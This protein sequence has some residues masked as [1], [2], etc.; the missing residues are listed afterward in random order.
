[1]REGVR[2]LM[3]MKPC[4]AVIGL[5]PDADHSLEVCDAN[6]VA[7]SVEHLSFWGSGAWM[8]EGT[9]LGQAVNQLVPEATSD[10]ILLWGNPSGLLVVDWAVMTADLF[11]G[12]RSSAGGN[13]SAGW[14]FLHR[15]AFE[16]VNGC[17]PLLRSPSLL[18]TD[19]LG[20]LEAQ[21]MRLIPPLHC[22]RSLHC[23]DQRNA[24]KGMSQLA[25]MTWQQAVDLARCVADL[26]ADA[27]LLVSHP[28]GPAQTAALPSSLQRKWLRIWRLTFWSALLLLPERIMKTCP[29][30]WFPA[31]HQDM[32]KPQPWQRFY[33]RWLRLVVSQL[34]R[35][36][37][38]V[39]H[40]AGGG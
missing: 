13:N 19:C 3:V 24:I 29:E 40:L 39:F 17:H 12:E 34:E 37:L 10:W 31:P 27:A 1:M 26:K 9:L 28:W 32:V 38:S 23:P 16:A 14:L 36:L 20:R 2:E 7:I 33:W 35:L 21:G 18:I 8:T 30:P 5:P 15:Q 25:S 22:D 4:I 6:G 11:C